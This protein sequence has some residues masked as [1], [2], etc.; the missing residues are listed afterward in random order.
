MVTI[1]IIMLIMGGGMVMINN[2]LA[3]E[4]VNQTAI[5]LVS[6]LNLA[7]NYATTS[8]LPTGVTSM[9]F[10]AVT[11][12]TNGMVSVMPVSVA[13]GI[14]ASFFAKNVAGNNVTLSKIDYGGLQFAVGDGKL[15]SVLAVPL[16]ATT[17]VGITVFTTETDDTSV[18]QINPFGTITVNAGL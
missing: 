2:F 7:R 3:K 1:T 4:R 15:V 11:V 12:T 6:L 10:V 16:P 9:D 17:A 14:G 5:E 18:I 8:Q 13:S